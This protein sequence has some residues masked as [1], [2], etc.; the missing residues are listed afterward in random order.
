[1]N[2]RTWRT[3]T[4]FLFALATLIVG[5]PVSADTGE[6]RPNFIFILTDD[7]G[8]QDLGAFGHPYLKTPNLDR[9]V[10]ESKRFTQFYVANPVCSPSRTALMTSRY[11]ARFAM[12][13]H[14]ATHEQ[15]AMR[16]MPNWLDPEAPFLARMLHDA[17]Y[18]TAH[19][20]KWHLGHGDGAPSPGEYGFDAHATY[21]SAGPLLGADE[22]E[23]FRR[24]HPE[25]S[26]KDELN[27][28]YIPH[29]RAHTTRMIVDEAIKFVREHR[30]DPFYVNLWTLLPHAPLDPTPE[31]LAPWKEL[32][33]RADSFASW[34]K[35]YAARAKDLRSQLQIYAASMAD[36]DTQL[37]RLLDG[38][39]ELNLHD[40]T[41]VIFSSD[42]GPEDYRIGNAANAGVG[43]PGPHRARKRSLYEGGVRVPF[44]VR[45]PNR[46]K[47]GTT[48]ETSVVGAVDL[49][50]TIC[51]LAGVKLPERFNSDGEDMSDVLLG[52]PRPRRGPLYWE[53][54][55]AVTGGGEYAPPRYA[56]RDGDWKLL[57]G[58]DRSRV[59]LYNIPRDP[60]E[61]HN[62]AA[63]YPRVV[64]RLAEKVLAWGK[65]L[66]PEP[67][68]EPAK[69][70]RGTQ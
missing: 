20:G 10:A 59:A 7:M 51:S 21:N 6:R 11:P 63:E 57:T 37:G 48:D 43:S 14:L 27:K 47:T 35:D 33:P 2:R 34:M 53:W 30:R 45:W 46:I 36:I 68:A 23:R 29:Y 4:T 26:S 22:I 1:M 66:P 62:V 28:E 15:N 5:R 31:Q 3:R 64:D 55:F 24:E 38:L 9:F 69:K 13:G 54:R 49:L 8:W 39:R 56:V 50:P 12:H 40:N 18:A 44:L 67:V 58:P 17:G 42:N 25:W 19:F 70:K 16:G 32:T 60:E 52:E 61:R 65:T 41:V